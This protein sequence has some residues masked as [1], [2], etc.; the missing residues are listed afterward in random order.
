MAVTFV[1]V[2]YLLKYLGVE[3]FGIW[4]TILTVLSWISLSNLGLG[5]GLR[6]YIA[7]YFTKKNY[8]QI[9][10]YISTTVA[11]SILLV[12]I[13]IILFKLTYAYFDIT[14]I[15]TGLTIPK[16]EVENAIFVSVI[17]FLIN[18]ISGLIPSILFGIQKS[19]LVTASQL[20]YNILFLLGIIFSINYQSEKL[21]TVSILYGLLIICVN[22][23]YG[24]KYVWF[25]KLKF[26]ITDI[27]FSLSEKILKVG[28]GFF[29]LQL[30]SVVLFTSDNFIIAKFIGVEQVSKYSILGKLFFLIINLFS[31]I[32]IQLW[33]SVTSAYAREDW[34]WINKT[35][36]NIRNLLIV[37]IF[38]IL[39]IIL[40]Y[41]DI[42]LL[43]IGEDLDI[44]NYLVILFGIYTVIHLWNA[45]Y[46]NVSN[47]LGVL[48]VQTW[49][50]L[51][52]AIINIPL[53]Y[54]L[55]NTYNLGLY[56]VLIAKIATISIS[57]ISSTY[58]VK[59]FLNEKSIS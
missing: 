4:Q 48:K 2:P 10:S 3:R 43:W 31:I 42:I 39:L 26:S 22:L 1:T 18:M 29:L 12:T 9:R 17:L 36:K 34:R 21:L 44:S 40:F 37:P 25:S 58:V 55:I 53:A 13:L 57:A 23:I 56:A 38:A 41:K 6:N 27:N 7:V 33:S 50:Y 46:V 24:I 45:I 14:S 32:L 15:F 59:S 19:Y 28:G 16:H 49:S 5:N 30:S 20:S 54:Y 47:G 8:P 51:I 35:I 52:G 11:I